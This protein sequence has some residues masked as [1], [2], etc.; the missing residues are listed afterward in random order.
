MRIFTVLFVLCLLVFVLA[1]SPA[2]AFDSQSLVGEWTGDW[3][4]SGLSGK[5]YLTIKSINDGKVK[6]SVFVYSTARYANRELPI[7]GT[8]TSDGVLSLNNDYL[9]LSLN[10]ISSSHIEGTSW[11]GLYNANV[12]VDKLK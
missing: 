6:G 7:S 11:D 1:L 5:F 2:I 8:L 4:Y 12:K 9:R 10:V 3:Q